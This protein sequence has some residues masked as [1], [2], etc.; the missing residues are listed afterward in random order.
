MRVWVGVRADLTL[1]TNGWTGSGL[2]LRG[3]SYPYGTWTSK[4]TP[5][6]TSVHIDPNS[7][8]GQVRVTAYY[9]CP[10]VLGD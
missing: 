9:S 6:C 3:D 4:V 5:R 1:G 2:P 10:V 7:E 8:V